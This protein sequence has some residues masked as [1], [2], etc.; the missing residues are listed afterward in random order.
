M[1]SIPP[2]VDIPSYQIAP[3]GVI[4][5]DYI[6][7][8]D[9]YDSL[10]IEPEYSLDGG[11]TWSPASVIGQTANILSTNYQGTLRWQT[12]LDAV[13]TRTN[14]TLV[15]RLTPADTPDPVPNGVPQSVPISLMA[16]PLAI[17]DI[18]VEVT[19]DIS[20]GFYF[21]VSENR[22]LE[23]FVFQY[24]LNEG[25]TWL[26]ARVTQPERFDRLPPDSVLAIWESATDLP[27]YDA[28]NVQFRVS[29]S[30]GRRLGRWDATAPFHLDNNTPPSV[31]IVGVN[32]KDLV[33]LQYRIE[34][35][36]R[37]P[38]DLAME[39]SKDGG[40]SWERATVSGD[41]Q[42]ITEPD[43]EG[44]IRWYANFDIP[45]LRTFPVRIR[46]SAS[47]H[48]TGPVFDTKDFFLKPSL[49]AQRT[50]GVTEEDLRLTY[51]TTTPTATP[52]QPEYSTDGGRTW[53]AAT[54]TRVSDQPTDPGIERSINW[55]VESDVPLQIRKVERFFNA[56]NNIQDPR[57]M[58]DLV[59][60]S[61]SRYDRNPNARLRAIQA[62]RILQPRPPWVIEGLVA[63]LLD[64]DNDVNR[65]AASLLRPV[66]D[67]APVASAL[68]A[69][70][71]YWAQQA[72]ATEQQLA[73]NTETEFYGNTVSALRKYRA[74]NSDL[75]SFFES[76]GYPRAKAEQMVQQLNMFKFERQLRGRRDR[77]EIT[78]PE[79]ERLLAEEIRRE[80]ESEP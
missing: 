23:N 42:H 1:S 22:Q 71:R 63:T 26:P 73:L 39:F 33:E 8:D 34:D 10:R 43:Y 6:L 60:M 35:A 59:R 75:I 41:M 47:D 49:F 44:I 21:P 51:Q 46:I 52:V 56:L 69:Y 61:L 29:T 70:D 78:P 80:Y 17:Q 58:P 62:I 30:L 77:G 57:V 54:V 24:S 15:F 11:R 79:Y 68:Q 50:R 16:H 27:G 2:R 66:A 38:V 76:R 18:P 36:E 53:S 12:A 9:E 37:D 40:I 28:T 3:D 72:R 14:V 4:T 19:G 48:D 7:Y 5:F 25:R 13:T 74:S 64:T 65:A 55:A 45:E 67:Q 31:R 20:F 32:E